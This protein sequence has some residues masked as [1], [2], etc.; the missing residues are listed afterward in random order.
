MLGPPLE[1]LGFRPEVCKWNPWAFFGLPC[2]LN[3][4]QSFRSQVN[5][6]VKFQ[7]KMGPWPK[8][9]ENPCCRLSLLLI[10]LKTSN[11]TIY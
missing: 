4:P 1:I 6:K 3:G 7:V 5:S 11:L 8:T 9:L 2:A 10:Q